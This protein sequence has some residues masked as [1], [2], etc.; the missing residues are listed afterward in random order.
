[1]MVKP[2]THPASFRD[3]KGSVFSVNGVFYRQLRPDA[4]DFFESLVADGRLR[5][6]S[7]EARLVG[8]EPADIEPVNPAFD[9]RGLR[10]D[11]VPVQSYPWEWSFEM[12]RDAA[13]A[14]L[15]L[16]AAAIP[17]GLNL[18]DGTAL[19]LTFH[20]GRMTW[21]DALSLTFLKDR[22]L[23]TGYRQF[24]QTQL[25]PLLIEAHTGVDP[26][27]WLR[28]S[29]DGISAIDA[30]AV[31][32]WKRVLR[33][34]VLQHVLLHSF[35]EKRV[36]KRS[37]IGAPRT[38]NTKGLSP[39]MLAATV[40]SY[41]KTVKKLL[42]PRSISHWE[43]YTETNTYSEEDTAIKGDAVRQFLADIRPIRVAD[44]GCNTGY[45]TDIAAEIADLVLALDADRACIDR[46]IADRS[47]KAL[48]KIV[49]I[50]ADLMMPSNGHGWEG[51]ESKPLIERIGSDA[52]LAL[53]LIHH[54][55]IGRNLPLSMFVDLLVK[56]A[57]C[58]VVEWVGKEDPMAQALLANREATFDLYNEDEF[59]KE[60][61]QRFE[62]VQSV[63]TLLENRKLYLLRSN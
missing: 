57:P 19:N 18:K 10:H 60:C 51:R 29:I 32:G 63:P 44:L 48:E 16:L 26:T 61:E 54:L 9:R 62:V 40:R 25:F 6:L 23:W 14:T 1:M 59:R 35:L 36:L 5:R 55:C 42:P 3:P 13:I 28:G 37:V 58:G 21:L 41:A 50:V 33:P 49:P 47:P 11:T 39:E 38:S 8:S 27:P 4:A 34:G 52:F 31:L 45:Y 17:L 7:N 15:E 56:I 24:C 53:A 2:Q 20:K 30:A 22:D 46:L 12:R 43:N